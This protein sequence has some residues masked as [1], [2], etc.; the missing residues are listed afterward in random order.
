MNTVPMFDPSTTMI[1]R[2][3]ARFS[4]A[5][6]FTLIEL[7][8]VIAIIAI[9]AAILFP[10]FA[11]AREKAR[12]SSC[13]SNM[14][15]MGLAFM[16]YAQDYDERFPPVVGCAVPII[17]CPPQSFQHVLTDMVGGLN[18]N[19][20]PAGVIVPS[21]TG[22][23]IR[24]NQIQQCPSSPIRPNLNTTAVAYMYNDLTAN[25]SQAVFGGVAQTILLSESTPASGHFNTPAA[26]SPLRLNVG[27]AVNRPVPGPGV[28]GA[29][30]VAIPTAAA[31]NVLQTLAPNALIPLDVADA[32][33]V[34][35]HAGGGNFLFADGHVKWHRINFAA[36]GVPQTVYF[37][38]A[39]FTRQN[40]VTNN[41]LVFQE[42]INEPV[43]GGNMMGWAA[44]F[45]TN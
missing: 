40:A 43:P 2:S 41:T 28:Q 30:P 29:Y 27:H 18:T 1:R 35:R 4:P 44:T 5:A 19:Q 21:L 26:A 32:D 7:L 38:P 9:L 10:V 8:V 23:Y 13:Q 20:V 25:R 31:I 36:N 11:Q 45:H 37:P 6:A 22:P 17:P 12:Q 16:Q 3:R 39:N 24:N 34:M 42:G 14:K 33:D 15:Q